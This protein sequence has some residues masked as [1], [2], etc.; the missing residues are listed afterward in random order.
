MV[1]PLLPVACAFRETGAYS[2]C[3]QQHNETHAAS[4][5]SSGH[6]TTLVFQPPRMKYKTPTTPSKISARKMAQNTP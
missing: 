1:L 4:H 5:L 2:N 3:A 6:H